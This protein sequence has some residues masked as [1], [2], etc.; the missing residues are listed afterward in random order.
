M[1]VA[2]DDSEH[3]KKAILAFLEAFEEMGYGQSSDMSYPAEWDD[4]L[5]IAYKLRDD[6]QRAISTMEP[7]FSIIKIF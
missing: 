7:V 1:I 5:G 4:L 2:N 6:K 3:M